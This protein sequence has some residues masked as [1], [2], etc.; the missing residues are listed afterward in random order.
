MG[1]TVRYIAEVTDPVTGD[2]VTLT[3]ESPA[4]LDQMVEA[5]LAHDY[6]PQPRPVGDEDDR[7][8]GSPAPGYR[9]QA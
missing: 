6:P 1:N 4:A 2:R 5:H 9:Q 7:A 8:A 3:A